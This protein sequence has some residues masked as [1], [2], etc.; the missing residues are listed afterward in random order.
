MY[1]IYIHRKV[2]YKPMQNGRY[3]LS[4]SYMICTGWANAYC[5]EVFIM[6]VGLKELENYIHSS[7]RASGVNEE[8]A[9]WATE[10]FIRATLRGVGHHDIYNLPERLRD[11][12]SGTTNANPSITMLRSFQTM[13]SYDGDNGLGEVCSTFIMERA[14]KLADKFGMALCTIRTSNHFLA[15]APYV[16]KAAEEGYISLLYTKG[17]PSMGAPGKTG[18]VISA[19]PMGFAAPTGKEFPIMM[20]ICMAYASNGLLDAKIKAGEKVPSYWGTDAGGN[21]TTDPQLMKTG[22][23]RAPIG[24]HKGFGLSMFGEFF[25]G[26]LSQGEIV[27]EKNPKTGTMVSSQAA[28]IFKPDGLV[29]LEEFKARTGEMIDRYDSR[30]PGVH[31]PGQGS[32][33]CRRKLESEKSIE[34]EDKLINELNKW[35]KELDINQLA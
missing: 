7:L 15:A 11:L 24:G 6:R 21:P 30:C 18:K 10:V 31:I 1:A 27:D 4:R 2:F 13:E 14:K 23:T 16:E 9:G 20:D 29:P 26:V 5:K 12:K 8:H 22:G 3:M 33:E 34:L 35:A 28:I 19:C 17:Q 25:T 32:Y